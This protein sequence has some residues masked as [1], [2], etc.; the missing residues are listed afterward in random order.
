M[1][2]RLSVLDQTIAA[3]GQPAH[4]A[5]RNTVA[6]AQHCERLGYARFWVSE[7]HNHPT[8]LGTAPEILISA[9]AVTT[10]AY[11]RR[12]RRDHA[13]ALRAVQSRRAVPR[14]RR[15]GAWAY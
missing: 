14:A 9:I 12:Q 2:Q 6:L 8:I 5:I 7:H 1:V 10:I 13:A 15:P 11:P 4:V 3:A